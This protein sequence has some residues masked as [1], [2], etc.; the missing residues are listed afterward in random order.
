MVSPYYLKIW[1][2]LNSDGD[3]FD[4]DETVFQVQ[5]NVGILSG[6]LFIPLYASGTTRMRASLK[7]GDVLYP[8]DDGFMGEVEDYTVKFVSQD[9][10]PDPYGVDELLVYP[11]P[12][13]GDILHVVIPGL[14]GT[15]RIQVFSGD[16]ETVRS[17]KVSQEDFTINTTFL[18]NGIFFI[19]IMV[20]DEVYV[21]RLIKI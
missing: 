20:G 21:R 4:W 14:Q 19:K 9:T 5:N 3:Y 1:M 12:L 6:V 7:A 17:G 11:N 10:I 8:C 2:D 15:A 18:K 16:G 13:D